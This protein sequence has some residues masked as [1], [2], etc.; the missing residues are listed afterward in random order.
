[1]VEKTLFN[2]D[3]DVNIW[4]KINGNNVDRSNS[5][6]GFVSPSIKS[7]P[8]ISPLSSLSRVLLYSLTNIADSSGLGAKK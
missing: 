2:G 8:Y 3:L 5:V 6:E 4:L 1:M 7:L